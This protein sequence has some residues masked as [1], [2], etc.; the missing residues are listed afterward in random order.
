ML[1]IRLRL[2]GFGVAGGGAFG[3]PGVNASASIRSLSCG[4]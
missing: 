3:A 4:R 1:A 2:F